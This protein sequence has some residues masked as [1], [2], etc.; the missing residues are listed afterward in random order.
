MDD[1]IKKD[2]WRLLEQYFNHKHERQLVKHLID[3]F[4]DFCLNSIENIIR[5]FNPIDSFHCFDA[6]LDGHKYRLSV[7]I[8]NACLSKPMIH[9]RD[10]TVKLMTPN[11]ARLR[12]FTYAAPL[13]VDLKF[14]ASTLGGETESRQLTGVSLGKIPIMVR[15][16][17]CVLGSALNLQLHEECPYDPGGYFIVNGNEKVV[18]SHDRIAE[19]RTFC[20]QNAKASIYSHIADVRSMSEPRNGVPK[21]TALKLSLKPN[22]YGR[23][24][25]VSV[26]RIKVDIP[27]FILFRALGILSD[28]DIV[29]VCECEL[30]E[31]AGCVHDADIYTQEGAIEF[32]AR[33]LQVIYTSSTGMTSVDQV[34]TVLTKDLLPHVGP[35]RQKKAEYLGHMVRKLILCTTGRL[36]L[37]DRDSYINKRIDAPGV[38]LSSLFRQHYSKVVKDLKNMLHKEVASGLKYGLST[39]NWGIKTVKI[40]QGVAQVLNRMTSSATLSHLRRVAT[41]MVEKASSGRLI[42]PRKL[43]GTQWGVVCPSETPEGASVGLVKNLALMTCISMYSDPEHLTNLVLLL[44]NSVR[45]NHH[46]TKVMING[47]F[48]AETSEPAILQKTLRAWKRS[49]TIHVMTAICW[50]IDRRIMSLSTEAGRCIRPLLVAGRLSD[51]AGKTWPH[52]VLAGVIEYMDVEEVSLARI[53]MTP[54]DMQGCTHVEMDPALM[55]GVLAG[56]IPFSDHNQAPRNTYQSAMGKQA[57]G[58]YSSAFRQRYDTMAHVLNYPQKP[59]VYTRTGLATNVDRMPCGVNLVVAIA[60]WTGYN[61]EDSIVMNNSSKQRGMLL[62]TY[63]RTYK[64]QCNKNHSS[65]EEETFCRPDPSYVNCNRPFNYDKLDADGFVPLGTFVD[66]GDIIIGKTMGTKDT[67][68]ALRGMERGFVDRN[69]YNHSHFTNVNNDGYTFAKVRIRGDRHPT[70]G[71]KFCVPVDHQVLTSQGWVK[72]S[73]LTMEHHCAQLCAGQALEPS[74]MSIIPG[75][76]LEVTCVLSPPKR[77]IVGCIEVPSS[78]FFVRAGPGLPGLWTGNSSR[79]GQKGTVGMLYDQVDMPFTASGLVPDIII[80][81]HAIPSRMTVAQLMECVMGKACCSIGTF[82][83]A[84]PFNNVSIQDIQKALVEQCGLEPNGNELLYNSRTGE[85]IQAQI[86]MGPT[87]YQRLKHMVVDKIHSRGASG[88]VVMLTRQPAEGRA[89]EGGLRLGEMEVECN[90]AHGTLQFLKERFMECSDNFRVFVCKRCGM[91]MPANPEVKF[92]ECCACRNNIA[93]GEIR[94][95]YATKLFLQ[96][97]ESMHIGTRFIL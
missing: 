12:G 42:Q 6:A 39:G 10:G 57:I 89:R 87:F 69:C 46:R 18:I 82:G 79:H 67:S 31:L 54:K 19:N 44:C 90:W 96:E 91:M 11:E 1:H 37:D 55:L 61:Q 16:R 2:V 94:I 20:F 35:D 33:N 81:P 52:A 30:E 50:H 51:L 77:Q 29:D 56:S 92:F 24:I 74:T 32:M 14:T 23:Y 70:I 71:D 76:T 22:Q 36:P 17:Y 21:T 83:D 47:R 15:S 73:D 34:Q 48:V 80:N 93:F 43:H 65:G 3:S 59:L 97:I 60:C 40:K 28:K 5:I 95:P 63:F 72:L 85:Q 75:G 84:T 58:L 13:T 68:I 25:R 8:C 9:E 26:Q 66:S 88:P 86:F 78:V 45:P 64:A 62:S 4:D 49:G 7:E 38:L 27:L 53:A 41:L